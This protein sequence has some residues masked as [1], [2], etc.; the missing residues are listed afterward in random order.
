MEAQLSDFQE[1][2]VMHQTCLTTDHRN[3]AALHA[4]ICCHVGV[5]A[6]VAMSSWTGLHKCSACQVRANLLSMPSVP[7]STSFQDIL[8]FCLLS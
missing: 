5:L 4:S 7:N 8:L 3:S 1:D 6:V 2:S